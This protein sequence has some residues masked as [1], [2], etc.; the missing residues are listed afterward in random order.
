MK[1]KQTV[2]QQA[3]K[4]KIYSLWLQQPADHIWL[5]VRQPEE[6]REGIIP[7]SQTLCLGDLQTFLP[8]LDPSKTYVCICRSGGR[9]GRACQLLAASGFKHL[10]NFDGGMLAWYQAAYPTES[11]DDDRSL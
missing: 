1:A 6:W 2:I 11:V 8:Q 5:D 4:S 7:K 3:D 10:I 9:S